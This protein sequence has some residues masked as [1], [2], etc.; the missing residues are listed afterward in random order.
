MSIITTDE[1]SVSLL[2]VEDEPDA[3]EMLSEIIRFKY[4]E[5]KLF[6]ANDGKA[7]L[8]MF[9]RHEPDIVITDI[10]MP[11]FN[12]IE[13]AF[14]IKVL[15]SSTEIIALTA[16]TDTQYLMRAIEIGINNYILKPIDVVQIYKVIDKTLAIIR[17]DRTIARQNAEIRQLNTELTKKTEDLEQANA[18]LESYDY[19]VA[20][21]LRS[22]MVSISGYSQMLIKE[23]A[24]QLDEEGKKCLVL[25]NKEIN[26][27]NTF[28]GAMLKLAVHSRKHADKFKTDLSSIAVEISNNLQESEPH[29]KVTFCIKEGLIG[30]CDPNLIRIVLENLF[31]NA[32][33]YSTTNENAR[34]EF[35]TIHSE[36]D[37]VYFVRDNGSGFNNCDSE[38][39]F[40]PF[41][42]LQNGCNTEGFG[43]GLASARR[44]IVRHGGKI[45]AEGE[46][47]KGATIYFTL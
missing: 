33:K 6:V 37:Q 46:E 31:G 21:D 24:P 35:G 27:M 43:I 4:P 38:K 44:I 29:R 22:P 32:W 23:C 7:G 9:K 16:H 14:E 15:R 45:W 13:M 1:Q 8:E 10:N 34:I 40:T 2:Y 42:R 28:V 19:S 11:A 17:S 3:Q 25:I 18:N 39:I 30:Y 12:G 41:Q 47:G 36:D 26:R 20:H 5:L